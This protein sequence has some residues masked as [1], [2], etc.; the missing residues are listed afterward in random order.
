[1][2][3]FAPYGLGEPEVLT[4]RERFATWPRDAADDV[5]GHRMHELAAST[6]VAPFPEQ[7]S[8]VDPGA[9]VVHEEGGSWFMGDVCDVEFCASCAPR[10]LSM[11]NS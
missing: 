5:E 9:R 2:E 6:E 7:G 11:T 8:G 1:L 10:S 3:A 4:L